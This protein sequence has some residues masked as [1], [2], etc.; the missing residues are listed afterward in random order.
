M[1]FLSSLLSLI[2]L[3]GGA[4]AYAESVV[5]YGISLADIPLTSGQPDRGAGAYQFTGYTLYDPLVAWEM[6]VADRPGKLVPGL[7]TKWEVDPAD[8]KKWIFTLRDGVKFHD[9]SAFDADAVVWNLAKVLDDKAPQFDKR[10]SAQVKPRL[11]SVASW[12]KID[13]K[14]VEITT[15]EV[16]S[17]FPY[18]ML[19]FLV[20]SPAQYETLGR[21]WDKFAASPSG[22][23]PFKLD[24]LVPRERAELIKNADYWNKSRLPKTDRMVLIPMPEA[25][26]RTNALLAGQVDLIETPAPDVVPRLKQA[27]MTIVTNV[28]PHV[29]NYHLSM[30]PGSPWTD[31]RLRRALNLAVDRDAMLELL[32]G[33]G[34][35]AIGQVDPS[36]PWF[37]T[38]SFKIKHDVAEAKRLVKEAGYSPEKPLKTT[39]VIAQGGTGQML[40]LPMNEF[41]QESFKEIGI[42]VDF[43]VVELEALYTYWRKGAKDE[44]SAGLTA[45]NIAYVTSDPLYAIIRFFHSGQVAPT[46]VN[47]GYYKNEKVDAILDEAKQ[48][49]DPKKQD[50]LMAAAHG[51][52]VD[53]A[54]LVWVVHDTNPHALSPKVKK[55]VQAQHWFQDLT[56]IGM[57]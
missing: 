34:K 4:P 44:M 25:L 42:Q 35:P 45:N 46:G 23:G 19:W 40:S 52:I 57:E 49:F 53:D 24:K 43:K 32:N 7:A 20:S 38:P 18:Q 8:K 39:F 15:K 26:S 17:F 31:V 11:P 12:R 16:D 55:F 6:D 29:W 41:L 9:G 21:D 47:W 13:D 5:R 3:V 30:L 28:T 10:Q 2:L 51:L 14:T 48:T 1:R 50:E 36:S 56:T 22:T 37:G 54:P 33:L 27:G